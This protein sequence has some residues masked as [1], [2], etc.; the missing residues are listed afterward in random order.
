[1]GVVYTRDP[2]A[3]RFDALS[4]RL[5]DAAYAD[6]GEWAGFILPP[7][8]PRARIWMTAHGI[9]P[10]QR[11]RWGELRYVR[12]FKRSVFW[13]VKWY[14]GV[15]GLRGTRNTASGGAK[16][17]WG[18]PV[19]V[20]WQTGRLVDLP[21]SYLAGQAVRIRIWDN[22]DKTRRTGHARAIRLGENWI[23]ADGTPNE[24]QSTPDDRA[25]E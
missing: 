24:R 4:R 14:G 2:L 13:Q 17:H 22:T 19:R 23:D 8:G 25:W 7:P 11:D 3:Q 16:S 15:T 10:Y 1:M 5:I 9:Q 21:G 20:E 18:A 12:A 6:K